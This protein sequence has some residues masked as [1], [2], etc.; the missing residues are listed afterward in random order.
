MRL[1]LLVALWWRGRRGRGCRIS[2]ARRRRSRVLL[3]ATPRTTR[4]I[5]IGLRSTG[6]LAAVGGGGGGVGVGGSSLALALG[7]C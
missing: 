7:R 1:A 4:S 2:G 3:G 5:V 6:T